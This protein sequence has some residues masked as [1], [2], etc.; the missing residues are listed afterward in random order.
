MGRWAPVKEMQA[1]QAADN[2]G[3]IQRVLLAAH[4]DLQAVWRNPEL[5]QT[6]IKMPLPT[7]HMLLSSGKLAKCLPRRC[8]FAH[9]PAI[10][11]GSAIWPRHSSP[12]NRRRW[13]LQ[14]W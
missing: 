2:D 11:R 7:I 12:G 14:P 5:S 1:V 4:V 13:L 9:S 8:H 6:L 10:L 3:L